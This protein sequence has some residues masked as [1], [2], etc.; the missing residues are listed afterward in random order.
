MI[1]QVIAIRDMHCLMCSMT[2]DGALENLPG[3]SE[4][5]T[6]FVRAQTE[7]TFDPSAVSL[8]ALVAAIRQAGYEPVLPDEAQIG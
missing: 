8:E 3:V 6:S 5:N 2:I 7:V 4:A 1:K